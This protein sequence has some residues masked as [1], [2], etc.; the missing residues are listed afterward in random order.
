[1]AIT[2]DSIDAA[3]HSIKVSDGINENQEG[4]VEEESKIEPMEDDVIQD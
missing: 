3:L 2:L 4:P 1:M